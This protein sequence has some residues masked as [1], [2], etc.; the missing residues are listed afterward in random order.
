MIQPNDPTSS[1]RKRGRKSKPYRDSTGKYI[2]GLRQRSDGRWVIVE[3]GETF[4][5]PDERRAIARFRQWQAKHQDK[6]VMLYGMAHAEYQMREKANGKGGIR[7]K[8]LLT[9]S[10]IYESEVWA[11]V[12][13]QLIAR[14][15]Y[16]AEQ[17]GIP[18]VGRLADLPVRTPSPTLKELG[19]LYADK[20]EAQRK[21]V[22]QTELFWQ[23]FTQWLDKHQV[24]TVKQ[25]TTGLLADYADHEKAIARELRNNGEDGGSLKYLKHRF[26]SIRRVFNFA[27]KRGVHPNDLRYALDCCAVLTLPKHKTLIDPHPIDP[28]DFHRLLDHAEAPRMRAYLLVMLNLCM[29]PKEAVSLD[30]GDIDLVKKIVCTQRG[31]T[32]IIRAGMLWDETVEALHQIRPQ[33]VMPRDQAVF[34]SREGSRWDPRSSN[35]MFRKLRK[36]AGVDAS[37]KSADFRDGAYTAAIQ[38]GASVDETKLL[39]GHAIGISDHYLARNP[40]MVEPAIK[41]IYHHYFGANKKV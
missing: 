8:F 28:V 14:P 2:N 35:A 31:K 13:E 19:K 15:E 10:D 4:T 5:E 29:Y 7:T 36:R 23:A 41:G 20:C 32:S 11:W 17:T 16:C 12:R 6:K 37:V 22:R 40:Q 25:L 27:R 1:P 33:W 9:Y 18:E 24:T 39:A 34:L 26:A 38:S 30:W 3:T 21:Q